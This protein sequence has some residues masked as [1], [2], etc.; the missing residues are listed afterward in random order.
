MADTIQAIINGIPYQTPSLDLK[1]RS[2]RAISKDFDRFTAICNKLAIDPVVKV[3]L[4]DVK[5][6]TPASAQRIALCLWD[7]AD[8]ARRLGFETVPEFSPADDFSKLT[9]NEHDAS[10]YNSSTQNGLHS[11]DGNAVGAT[12]PPPLSSTAPPR[13]PLPF[14]PPLPLDTSPEIA[15]QRAK[16]AMPSVPKTKKSKS[17]SSSSTTTAAA[18][19]ATAGTKNKTEEVD[20]SSV[21]ATKENKTAFMTKTPPAVESLPTSAHGGT[22]TGSIIQNNNNINNSNVV[23]D[24]SVDVLTSILS[25]EKN[26]PAHARVM[27]ALIRGGGDEEVDVGGNGKATQ[28]DVDTKYNGTRKSS[29]GTSNATTKTSTSTTKEQRHGWLRKI[30]VVVV[31]VGA[32][33]VVKGV[34]GHNGGSGGSGGRKRRTIGIDADLERMHEGIPLR[35]TSKNSGGVGAGR[36]QWVHAGRW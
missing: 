9:S 29:N 14:I 22:G 16:N 30:G 5:T 28:V 32:V 26:K 6:C 2:S 25:P 35:N 21:A 20:A 11:I 31:V 1:D 24:G 12:T 33:L 19:A 4:S 27:N 34:F 23:V 8:A 17:S 13:K 7:V 18:A 3:A 10:E 15:K 36:K